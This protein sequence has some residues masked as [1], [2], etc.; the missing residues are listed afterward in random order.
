M[1]N[2]SLACAHNPYL[3]DFLVGIEER[4]D[5][6]LI[7]VPRYAAGRCAAIHDRRV[8][9]GRAG[10]EQPACAAAHRRGPRPRPRASAGARC[11][12]VRCSGDGTEIT[13]DVH[14]HPPQY[15]KAP[16]PR[17]RGEFWNIGL[18][19]R[20]GSARQHQLGRLRGGSAGRLLDRLR[21]GLAPRHGC[22]AGQ[23]PLHRSRYQGEYQP[24]P[25]RSCA[26]TCPADRPMVTA[27]TRSHLLPTS[28]SAAGP[29]WACAGS[30]SAQPPTTR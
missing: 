24:R 14:T 7:S 4:A 8:I 26:R 27:P 30:S 5:L 20:P 2:A 23:E 22:A 9:L 16:R 25:R 11:S 29:T 18:A 12:A 17:R 13:A 10:A 15:M 28:S 21:G 3:A 1:F 19:T 6:Y